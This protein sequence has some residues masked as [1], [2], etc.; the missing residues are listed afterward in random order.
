MILIFGFNIW[1]VYI[2]FQKIFLSSIF[3]LLLGDLFPI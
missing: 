1:F 2:I 3:S